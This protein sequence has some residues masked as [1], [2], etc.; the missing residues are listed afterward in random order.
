MLQQ[1][2][3]QGFQK[4]SPIQAH[5]WPILLSGK[6]MIGISQTGSG[7]YIGNLLSHIECR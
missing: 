2:E 5:S 4:P 3:R 6:D 1:I 7:I